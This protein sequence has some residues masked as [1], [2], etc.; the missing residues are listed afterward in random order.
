[1]TTSESKVVIKEH[2]ATEKSGK[3]FSVYLVGVPCVYAMLDKPRLKYQSKTEMEYSVTVFVTS[4]MRKQLEDAPI[5]KTFFEVGVDKNKKRAIK[6]PLS[7]QGGN[8][9]YDPFTGLH[10]VNLSCPAKTKAGKERHI[11][12]IDT[13][14]K[15]LTCKIGNE[16]VISVKLFG[17]VKD[18]LINVSINTVQVR[19][20]VPYVEKEENNTYD[21]VLGVDLGNAQT[22]P[23]EKV[24]D[25]DIPF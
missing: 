3:T 4:E 18:D 16:S 6:F 13:E 22:D 1:M 14:G 7:E 21:D 17:Y 2:E 5:N 19:H 20:L 24:A 8:G 9:T 23:V 11:K 25:E 15:P 12:V 10:G